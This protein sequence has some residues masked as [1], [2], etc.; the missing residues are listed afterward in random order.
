M[1]TEKTKQRASM[2]IVG[3]C[4]LV[5]AVGLVRTA[6]PMFHYFVIPK[7][8]GSERYIDSFI[9]YSVELTGWKIYAAT[10]VLVVSAVALVSASLYLMLSPRLRNKPPT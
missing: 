6:Y 2:I 1:V 10:I 8:T 4:C 3:I 7:L 9:I 5:T